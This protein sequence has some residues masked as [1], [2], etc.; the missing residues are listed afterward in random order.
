MTNQ[1]LMDNGIQSHPI[2]SSWLKILFY[3]EMSHIIKVEWFAN[4]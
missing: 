1:F 4:S 3:L 2:F